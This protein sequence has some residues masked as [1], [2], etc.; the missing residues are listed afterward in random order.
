MR[1]G[2]SLLLRDLPFALDRRKFVERDGRKKRRGPDSDF[3]LRRGETSTQLS[4]CLPLQGVQ[5]ENQ[6][7]MAPK[8]G[9]PSA[10]LRGIIWW[11]NTR[12][13]CHLKVIN[14][15]RGAASLGD[16]SKIL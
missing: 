5:T 15:C 16:A 9:L 12:K 13:I 1:F 7:A 8:G 4:G 14:D 3:S 11:I 6:Q 10:Q 2:W